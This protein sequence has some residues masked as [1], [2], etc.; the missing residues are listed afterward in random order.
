MVQAVEA[1][2][3]LLREVIECPSEQMLADMAALDWSLD[4]AFR[5]FSATLPDVNSVVAMDGDK[6]VAAMG[7]EQVDDVWYSWAATSPTFYDPRRPHF[8]LATK[9]Y[10]KRVA[11]ANPD[12]ALVMKPAVAPDDK[13]KNWMN[14]LGYSFLETHGL[15]VH[16]G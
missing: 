10:L 13:M 11:A 7:W 6:P 8:V 1:T 14:V 4:G 16:R 12:V 15:F 3:E 5:R 9:R 2:P